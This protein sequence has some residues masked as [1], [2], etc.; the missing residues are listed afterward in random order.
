MYCDKRLLSYM[1]IYGWIS[2]KQVARACRFTQTR[3]YFSHCRAQTILKD[4]FSLGTAVTL[5]STEPVNGLGLTSFF[6]RIS[7]T[8]C[9]ALCR[10]TGRRLNLYNITELQ[11]VYFLSLSNP[12]YSLKRMLHKQYICPWKRVV[13]YLQMTF[14]CL[15]VD[16][17]ITIIKFIC[18]H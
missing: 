15:V 18:V 6:L 3:D 17:N 1:Q 9:S 7:L 5:D 11:F 10:C 12:L 4:H 14:C 16:E 8:F 13:Q 2:V